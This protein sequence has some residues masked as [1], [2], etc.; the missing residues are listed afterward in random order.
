MSELSE[1]YVFHIPVFKFEDNRLIRID[2]D[3]YICNL[4]AMFAESGFEGMYSTMV[5]SYY[6]SRCYDEILITVFT[7]PEEAPEEIFRDWFVKNNDVFAQE[8]FAF[9][10]NGTMHIERLQNSYMI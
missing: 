8:A 2:I 6:K 1:K 7:S 10:H 9:E 3:G 4:V 5:K